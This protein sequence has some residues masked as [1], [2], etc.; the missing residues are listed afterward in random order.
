MPSLEAEF[1]ALTAN[2]FDLLRL[3]FAAGVTVFHAVALTAIAPDV[4][5]LAVLASA[6][7]VG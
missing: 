7:V 5:T 3:V 4:L 6:G 2:R 1:G